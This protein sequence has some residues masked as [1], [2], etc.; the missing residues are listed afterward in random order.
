[1]KKILR[2]YGANGTVVGWSWQVE[3]H[4]FKLSSL[5]HWSVH[6]D[7]KWPVCFSSS[8]KTKSINA[9]NSW[10]WNWDFRFKL[11]L[12][13]L[14]HF[15][16]FDYQNS[17]LKLLFIFC[18]QNFRNYWL[19]EAV[20]LRPSQVLL[21]LR[22]LIFQ[23]FLFFNFLPTIPDIFIFVPSFFSLF[24]FPPPLTN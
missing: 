24:Y 19:Y 22:F 21:L 1:M 5:L 17:P 4:F 20:R 2:N 9:W 18:S 10:K 7:N 3:F 6:L 16:W 12:S 15:E 23:L 11:S 13:I 8:M 14:L